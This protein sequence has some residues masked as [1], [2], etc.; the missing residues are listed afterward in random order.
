MIRT[1]QEWSNVTIGYPVDICVLS[2]SNYYVFVLT[3]MSYG[4]K[5]LLQPAALNQVALALDLAPRGVWI[6]CAECPDVTIGY[7]VD[8][9]VWSVS[10]GCKA[11]Q[12]NSSA[13]QFPKLGFILGLH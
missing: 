3:G 1:G 5:N 6:V 11:G 7:P 10:A 8:I 4:Q 9:C 2:V 13:T 12:K